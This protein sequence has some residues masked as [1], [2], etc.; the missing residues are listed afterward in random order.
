M[1][2]KNYLT[3]NEKKALFELKE[4]IT[5]EFPGAELILYGSKREGIITRIPT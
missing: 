1:E 2:N 3:E 4:K 5:E